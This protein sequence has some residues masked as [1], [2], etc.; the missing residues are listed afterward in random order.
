VSGHLTYGQRIAARDRAAL[1]RARRNRDK[2]ILS[3][4]EIDLRIESAIIEAV[5][6]RGTVTEADLFRA[7]VPRAAITE[8]R[9]TRCFDAA[10]QRDPAIGR[11]ESAA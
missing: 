4:G 8:G 7:N 2:D 11:V 5:I 10:R 6:A 9:F 3:S 1:R